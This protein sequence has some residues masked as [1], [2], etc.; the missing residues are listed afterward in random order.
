MDKAEL[1]SSQA[2]R[3]PSPPSAKRPALET[4]DMPPATKRPEDK[5]AGQEV[6]GAQPPDD[7]QWV[8]Y[9]EKVSNP[10]PFDFKKTH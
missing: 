10:I 5:D 4:P 3:A 7:P 9:T 6:A 1:Q 2:D 8:P